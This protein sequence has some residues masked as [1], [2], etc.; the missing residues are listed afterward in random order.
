MTT[1]R[2]D[3]AGY[4]KATLRGHLAICRV[5]HWVKNLFVIPGIVVALAMNRSPAESWSW[6]SWHILLGLAAVCLIVSSNYVLNEVLDAPTDRKHPTKRNRPVPSGRVSVPLAYVQWIALMAV[7][8]AIA[9]LVSSLLAL[10]LLVLWL[11]ACAYNIPPLRTKDIAFVDVLSE[12]VNNPL[13]MLAGWYMV[14]P[15]AVVPISLLLGYWMIGGYFMA[16]KRFAELRLINHQGTAVAYR[17]S[18]K[19]YTEE[20]LM[21]SVM[22]Y[23][24]AAMLLLGAFIMRYRLELVLAIPAISWVMGV[25]FHLSFQKDSPV[26]APEKL[27]KSRHLVLS[28]AACCAII[29]VLLYVDIAMVKTIFAPSEEE[30][31]RILSR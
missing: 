26:Q 22:F 21:G 8:L 9:L 2:A 27:Y 19:W 28:L 24:A 11:M 10:T 23:A 6:L 30:I 4:G 16:L 3:N 13:R 31:R 12:A 17:K 29:F 25:Y 5:D 15:H 14:E 7:G 20:L 1:Q 18:F